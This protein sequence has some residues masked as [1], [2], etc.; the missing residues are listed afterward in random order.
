MIPSVSVVR[1]DGLTG[2]VRPG[3]EGILAIVASTQTGTGTQNVAATYTRASALAADQGYGRLASLSAYAMGVSQHPI[4]A[5][6]PVASTS[7]TYVGVALTGTGT[8]APSA[9]TTIPVDNFAVSIKVVAGGT[10]GTPGITYQTSVDGGV[11]YGPVTA[12]GGANSIAI[13]N[14]GVTINFASGTLVAGDLITCTTTGP[15]PTSAD[16][17][18]ALEALR[19]TKQPWE[20]ALIDAPASSAIISQVDA[21]LAAMESVGQFKIA[22]LNT[23]MR[24]A[25]ESEATYAAAM[26]S[27]VS[28]SST[29]RCCVSADGGDSVDWNL[30]VNVP[31]PTSLAIASLAMRL[32]IGQDPAEVA[33]GALTNFSIL[34]AKSNPKYHNEE[35]FPTLDTLRLSTLRTFAGYS[36]GTYVTNALMLSPGG[37]DYVYLQHARVMNKACS[38]AWQGMTAKLSKGVKKSPKIGPN[39]ERYIAE[40]DAQAIEQYCNALFTNPLRGQVD[41]VQVVLRRD[42]DISSNQGAVVHADL[43]LVALA[44]IKGVVVR[45][46]FV[47]TLTVQL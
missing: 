45:T 4:V 8:S 27:V 35:D 39:K 22:M 11:T 32:P 23:R 37:S 36:Q 1:L 13:A 20:A 2:T 17:T 19:V 10:I 38:L 25:G 21:W 15:V 30:G 34:D 3:S 47:R 9:G 16:L 40:D 7:G 5:V 44:Y 29:V 24:N 42:D 18:A 14:T 46:S 43:Q 31:R 26:A 41:S 33:L 12:L 6:Q 28:S